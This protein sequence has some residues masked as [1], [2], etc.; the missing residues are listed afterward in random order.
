MTQLMKGIK[1]IPKLNYIAATITKNHIDYEL[2]GFKDKHLKFDIASI[3]KLFTATRILQLIE[4]KKL[5]LDTE[6]SGLLPIKDNEIT[7]ESCLFH[8]TGM[9]PSVR[10]V[11]QLT[12]ED[13]YTSIMNCD[14]QIT[15]TSYVYSCINFILLGY[16]VEKLDEMTLD[17]SIDQ[18][19]LKPLQMHNTSFN[20]QDKESCVPSE[21]DATRGV[22][23]GVVHDT[24]AFKLNGVSGN[25]GLF[26]TIEDL[27]KFVQDLIQD[28]SILLNK[29]SKALLKNHQTKDRYLGWN[30]LPSFNKHYHTGYTGPMLLVDFENHRG[31]VFLNNAIYPH[32][33][34]TNYKEYREEI[35][36]NFM[37]YL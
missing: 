23:Q 7:I 35:L 14:D 18:Y 5:K 21:I 6:I 24:T 3:T 2:E 13:I 26:S 29:E 19:I 8:E 25:A 12:K 20:P 36:N 31:L 1:Q 34:K 22:I 30:K 28:E 37:K 32:R 17:K 16:I 11:E 27:S 15:D 4:D 10:N 33:E 9:L